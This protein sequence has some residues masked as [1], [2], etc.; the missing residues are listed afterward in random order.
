MKTGAARL[1]KWA[2]GAEESGAG[3]GPSEGWNCYSMKDNPTMVMAARPSFGQEGV[4]TLRLAVPLVF[5]Q[6]AQMLMGVVDTVMVGRLGTVPLAA[7]A[8]A[9]TLLMVPLVFG[10]G[11]LSSVSMR[12][13]QAGGSGDKETGRTALRNGVGLAVGLALLGVVGFAL[14]LPVLGWFGQ[15]PEVTAATPVYLTTCACSLLPALLGMALKNHADAL[16]APWIP[17]W[18]MMGGVGLNALLNWFWIYGYAGFPACGLE[19]TGYATLV[20]RIAVTAGLFW[21]MRGSVRLRDWMPQ[22]WGR[23]GG[24]P[25]G[26]MGLLRL[27]LPAGL[28][29]LAEVSI[30]MVAALMVG[31]LGVVPMAAHQITVICASVTFMVPLGIAMAVTV[32]VG[33]LTGAGEIH[34][35][36]TVL[37]GGWSFGWLASLGSM[38]LFFGLG[39]EVAW[40]F[41][42]DAAVVEMAVPL[43]IVAGF[44]Q[45]G[46]ATQVISAGALRGVHDVRVPALLACGIYWGVAVPL[47][48]ALAFPMGQGA[49]GVWIGLAAGLGVAGVLLGRRAW[50]KLGV[51]LL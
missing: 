13:A 9:N 45:L 22:H 1:V 35:C 41:V 26:M 47:S 16:N 14:L 20:S 4:A 28:H 36:R 7:A 6:L 11:L 27:G 30:F 37:L 39:R 18:I 48:W 2:C 38:A 50:V 10:V 31:T 24:G 25:S 42:K 46:D 5:G 12:T 3:G 32:R 15:A 51:D 19:G 33:E 40:Q 23:G 44:F 49:Q 43:L 17:L 21:W 34:R 8:F 29:L